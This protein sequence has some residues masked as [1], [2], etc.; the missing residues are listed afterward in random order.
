[1]TNLNNIPTNTHQESFTH[2]QKIDALLDCLSQNFGDLD[3]NINVDW[4]DEVKKAFQVLLDD[5]DSE[6]LIDLIKQTGVDPNVVYSFLYQN[7]D[8]FKYESTVSKLANSV[9]S[10]IAKEFNLFADE[11]NKL[12]LIFL[13]LLTLLGITHLIK[14]SFKMIRDYFIDC[15]YGD[16]IKDQ[17]QSLAPGEKLTEEEKALIEKLIKAKKAGNVS[18]EDQKKLVKDISDKLKDN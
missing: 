1:M 10:R 4:S 16:F 2:E 9:S 12:K 3:S 14:I 5:Q 17:N 11:I 18:I 15:V 7:R 13:K 8:G 6:K